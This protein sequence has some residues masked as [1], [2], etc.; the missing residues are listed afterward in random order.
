MRL[1]MPGVF[2]Q[3]MR[4]EFAAVLTGSVLLIIVTCCDAIGLMASSAISGKR[5]GTFHQLCEEA[6]TDGGGVIVEVKGRVVQA[7][8]GAGA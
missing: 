3:I 1:G 4:A 7:C 8:A 2:D 6:G 5:L